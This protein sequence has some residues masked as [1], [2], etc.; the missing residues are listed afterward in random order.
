MLAA[1]AAMAATSWWTA[2]WVASTLGGAGLTARL[3]S[4]FL[5]VGAGVLSYGL[6]AHVLRVPEMA[7]LLA[8]VRQRRAEGTAAAP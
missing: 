8:T 5:P 2:A 7:A 6:A 1:T 3:T 4:V